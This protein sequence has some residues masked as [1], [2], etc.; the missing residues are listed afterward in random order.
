MYRTA[1][2][3]TNVESHYLS[4]LG[5]YEL[6][7]IFKNADNSPCWHKYYFRLEGKLNLKR[8]SQNRFEHHEK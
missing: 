6:F 4:N 1:Q 5:L 7:L 8:T 3:Q 2:I